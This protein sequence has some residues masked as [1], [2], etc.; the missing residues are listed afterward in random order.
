MAPGGISS[1]TV[2]TS[3]VAQRYLG[4]ATAAHCVFH[5]VLDV[6]VFKSIMRYLEPLE[7]DAVLVAALFETDVEAMC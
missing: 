3:S 5:D 6:E 1:T 7:E 2:V 4:I